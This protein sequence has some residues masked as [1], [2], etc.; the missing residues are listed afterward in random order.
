MIPLGVQLYSVRDQLTPDPDGVL[1]RLADLGYQFVEPT[2]GLLGGDPDGFRRLLHRHG[3]TAPSLHAPVL[4]P[5]RDEVADAARAIGAQT[6]VV[7]SI[8]ATEFGTAAGVARCADRLT[9]A[10]ADLTRHGLGLAYH[11]HHWELAERPGGQHALELLAA[12]L[13]EHIALELDL[14]WAAT[15]GADVPALLRRLGARVQFLHV[16][17]GPATLDAPMTAVGAGT[18][19]IDAYLTAA[20]PGARRIVEIDRCAGD[21]LTALADS[22]AYLRGLS[23]AVLGGGR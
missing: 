13:P 16:K 11:N 22:Y 12:L 7:A 15:G 8:P 3:L 1:R 21:M 17:D 4:G 5:T 10:A 9:E 18:L 20:A 23:P 2:L 6:V 19:P 14:Y